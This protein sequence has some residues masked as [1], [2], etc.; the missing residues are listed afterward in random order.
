MPHNVK[1]DDALFEA[2][3]DRS[4]FSLC[5]L[6]NFERDS[7]SILHVGNQIMCDVI[8]LALLSHSLPIAYKRLLLA[9]LRGETVITNPCRVPAKEKGSIWFQGLRSPMPALVKSIEVVAGQEVKTGELLCI[10]EAMKMET[11]L[12][13][14]QDGTVKP[15]DSIAE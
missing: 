3:L 10:I 15:G 13:T 9:A 4:P 11:M 8:D 12:R 5:A 1:L 7:A 6:G 14:E 2:Q